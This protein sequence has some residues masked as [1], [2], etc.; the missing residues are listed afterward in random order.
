[1]N[2]FMLVRV[3][4]IIVKNQYLSVKPYVLREFVLKMPFLR[5]DAMNWSYGLKN[6][7]TVRNW[8]EDESLR[9]VSE[10]RGQKF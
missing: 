3:T 2:I 8:S 9:Q 5:N 7:V 10:F 1:M 4:F 6:E